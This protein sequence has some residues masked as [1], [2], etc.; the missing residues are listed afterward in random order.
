MSRKNVISKEMAEN[1]VKQVFNIA[2]F[3]R[4]V[5][6]QPRG[7]NY[8]IFHKYVKEYNL[9]T[10]HFTGRKT[11]LGNKHKI[12]LSVNDFFKK[13]KL[14]KAS[15][16]RKKLFSENLKEYKCEICG[17]SSWRGQPI[18][19]QIHHIDGDHFNNELENLQILCPNCHTQTDSYAGKKNQ[20]GVS[21]TI[22]ERPRKHLCKN[23]GK[24][25][26]K[27]PKTGLCI[28]C[29]RESYK[30]KNKNK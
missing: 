6:W 9:D 15:D 26:H 1:I 19:L 4:M 5:G 17:I 21:T 24:A 20:K 7:D 29:L 13:D 27:P 28:S 2:D 25:L 30:L 8:K 18:R 12:G 10:S 22:Y 11:N 23:C 16:I 3:C 14:I